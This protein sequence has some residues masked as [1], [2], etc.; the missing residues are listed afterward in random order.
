[1]HPKA[2]KTERSTYV[3]FQTWRNASL[4]FGL[5]RMDSGTP[6]SIEWVDCIFTYI[7]QNNQ[8]LM[9]IQAPWI[10][11]ININ[12]VGMFTYICLI[13][14]A[15]VGKYTGAI[16]CFAFL[17]GRIWHPMSA[18]KNRDCHGVSKGVGSPIFL[19]WFSY[20]SLRI[21]EVFLTNPKGCQ[22]HPPRLGPSAGL[23]LTN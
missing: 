16:E 10:L 17:L 20:D 6:L 22:V 5:R 2:V 19:L 23:H 4:F 18:S 8:P 13:L 9:N 7:C 1:M 3:L 12:G 21:C 11:W 15:N 14:M